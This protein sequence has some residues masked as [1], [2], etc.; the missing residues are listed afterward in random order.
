MTDVG[1]HEILKILKDLCAIHHR[2]HNY[3]C[4]LLAQNNCSGPGRPNKCSIHYVCRTRPT[5]IKAYTLE[6]E[7]LLAEYPERAMEVLL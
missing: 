3:L 7:R 1:N 2:K 5:S 4:P 6:Y